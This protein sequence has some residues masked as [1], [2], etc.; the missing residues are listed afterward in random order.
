[1]D[2]IIKE[3]SCLT[4]KQREAYLLREEGFVM[5]CGT[6]QLNT[7]WDGKQPKEGGI[8]SGTGTIYLERFTITGFTV[9]T[10]AN[11]ATY[12][13]YYYNYYKSLGNDEATAKQKAQKNFDSLFEVSYN[14]MQ[15]YC[16]PMQIYDHENRYHKILADEE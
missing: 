3:L 16:D 13:D 9:R 2:E 4:E 1:M 14:N 12:M 15:E 7:I 6:S 8:A 11:A 10:Y 5:F